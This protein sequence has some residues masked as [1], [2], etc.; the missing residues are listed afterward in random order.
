MTSSLR[1][2]IHRRNHKERSQ[3]AHRTKL[4]LLEKHKDYVKRARDYHSKQDRL[5]R[6]RQKAADRNKDEF[7]FSMN[8]EKTQNGVHIKER[9]NVALPTDM[10]KVLKTQDENYVRTMRA[11]GLKKI[12]KLKTQLTSLANLIKS[13][14][15]EDEDASDNEDPLEEQDIELL[16]EAGVLPKSSKKGKGKLSNKHIVFVDTPD[17]ARRYASTSK[18]NRKSADSS[19]TETTQ[20]TEVDLGWQTPATTKSQKRR[21][22]TSEL[23]AVDNEAAEEREQ[24]ARSNRGRLLKELAAR[25]TRDKM[26]RYTEREFELQ[27]LMMGKGAR[28]KIQG[29]EPVGEDDSEDEDRPRRSVKVD[30][31]T[32]KPRVYKWRLE[33]K[34]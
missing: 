18:S 11:A 12:D 8:K 9:G 23:T 27:R 10:V 17:E 22:S 28:R 6:L 26:L 14:H 29:P 30:E 15:L 16:R 25:L 33:R 20:E 32:Y 21:Q 19:R 1:N 13:D 7:Y 24:L 3:L 2:S 5:T 31:K 4:G 34:R